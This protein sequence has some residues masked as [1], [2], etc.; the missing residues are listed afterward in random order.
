MCGRLG[1]TPHRL[2]QISNP[3]TIWS[4]CVRPFLLGHLV[5]HVSA[6]NENKKIESGN[7]HITLALCNFG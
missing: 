5:G 2:C 6:K 7:G 3:M 1:S 4:H